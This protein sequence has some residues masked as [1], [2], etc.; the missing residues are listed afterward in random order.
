MYA[1]LALLVNLV[2]LLACCQFDRL[3]VVP[4][5]SRSILFVIKMVSSLCK[6]VLASFV[7]VVVVVVR[8][9]VTV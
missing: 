6:A 5:F 4:G 1:D 2:I 3:M 8:I 9:A 7:S